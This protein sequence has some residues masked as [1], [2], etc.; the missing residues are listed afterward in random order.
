M[1]RQKTRANPFPEENV[2]AVHGLRLHE[3]KTCEQHCFLEKLGE[4]GCYKSPMKIM[5]STVSH[6]TLVA[7]F[8]AL[9]AP[10]SR[11]QTDASCPKCAEGNAP[12]E[13]FPIFSNTYYVGTHGISSIL[14]TSPRGHMLIDGSLYA[15][16]QIVGHIRQ[17]G[18]NIE[19]VKWIGNSHVPFDHSGSLAELQRLSGAQVAASRWSADVL[20][21]TGVGKGDPQFRDQRPTPLVHD[22]HV[23]KDGETLHVGSLAISAHFTPGHTQAA[24]VG[25]GDPVRMTVAC[26]SSTPTV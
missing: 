23:L 6:F 5:L 22:A 25:P 4:F 24:R 26:P 2:I 13:P 10:L 20:T 12:Q 7:M 18:V 16:P 9:A 11:A 19:D 8:A 3:S 14:L 21:K 15:A 1:R 17:L